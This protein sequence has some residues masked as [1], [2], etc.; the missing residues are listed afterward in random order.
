M[1]LKNISLTTKM[2]I[3]ISLLFFVIFAGGALLLFNHF[4]EEYKKIIANQQF[5]FIS[6]LANDTDKKLEEAKTL[7]KMSIGKPPDYVVNDAKRLQS[8]FM[9]K[10]KGKPFLNHFFD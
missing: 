3:T 2:A 8:Y 1:R 9:K 4:G 10:V 7:I 5:E 6:D